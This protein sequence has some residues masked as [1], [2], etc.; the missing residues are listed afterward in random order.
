MKRHQEALRQ[1]PRFLG[2][3]DHLV[4]LCCI[5]V[6]IDERPHQIISGIKKARCDCLTGS[7]SVHSLARGRIS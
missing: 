3:T 7:A 2:P 4:G 1:S 5:A 6:F